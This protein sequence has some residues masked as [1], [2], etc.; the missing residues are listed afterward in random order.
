MNIPLFIVDAFTQEPF[1]GNPAAVCLL[2]KP[3]DEGWMQSLAA[4]MNLSE[5][6]FV[7]RRQEGFGLRWFTPVTEVDL[8]GHATLASAHVLWQEGWL[9]EDEAAR[10][11]SRSGVLNARRSG[12][13][14]EMDF[15]AKI[16]EPAPPPEKLLPALG[17][18]KAEA[19]LYNG[20]DYL[21][22]LSDPGSVRR[23]DPDGGQLRAIDARGFI[24]TAPSDAPPYDF[25]SRFFA[26]G[27]GIAEDPVTGS[28]H[29]ALGPYW[30]RRLDKAELTGCQVSGRGGV[31]RVAMKEQGVVLAGQAVTVVGGL[32]MGKTG[33]TG[34]TQPEP[35]SGP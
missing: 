8:C 16:A 11:H 25:L 32:W 9:G 17:L 34:P 21:V 13:W 27:V 33:K 35:E 6:A 12:A 1:K 31:V 2:E 14:I 30:A 20:M 10:F 18:E 23:L 5:T 4:E 24:V 7:T 3:A 15:P 19:V 29:C 26:P 22:V 28:A